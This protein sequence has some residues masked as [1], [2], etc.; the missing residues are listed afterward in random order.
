MSSS[1]NEPAEI[2]V[3][4]SD[5]F[6]TQSVFGCDTYRMRSYHIWLDSYLIYVGTNKTTLF[7]YLFE[8][9]NCFRVFI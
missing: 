2:Q 8:W 1:S 4:S 3:T 5:Q 7:I 6:Q 9:I